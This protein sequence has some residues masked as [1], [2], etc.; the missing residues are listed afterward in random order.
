MSISG[1]ELKRQLLGDYYNTD[2]V[3]NKVANEMF[4]DNKMYPQEVISTP[5]HKTQLMKC[6]VELT[7][8]MVD[9]EKRTEA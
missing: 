2:H 1:K 9:I 5:Q 7:Q 8:K 6:L 4:K 3:I